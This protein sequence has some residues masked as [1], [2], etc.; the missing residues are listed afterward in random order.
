MKDEDG[1]DAL[2][3]EQGTSSA[4]MASTKF[5]D[6]IA[7]MPGNSGEDADA[8]GA[9]T[10]ILLEDS[11]KL[12]GKHVIPETWISL[13]YAQQPKWWHEMNNGAGII[14][15]VCPLIRNLYGHPLAGM[16]W[17][18]GSQKLILECGFEK[19]KGWESLYVHRKKQLFL[20]VYVDDFHMAGKA[21][22]LAPM[23][24]L[25][26]KKI[27]LDEPI[28]FNQNIYLGCTQTDVVIS[29]AAIKEKS[30]LFHS[31]DEDKTRRED[32]KLR[33][34]KE[35][36]IFAGM[37]LE[38]APV[39]APEQ[40]KA[41]AKSKWNPKDIGERKATAKQGKKDHN[42][43]PAKNETWKIPPRAW[44]YKMKG[45]AE[46]CVERYLEL[47]NAKRTSLTKVATP[48]IEDALLAPDDFISKGALSTCAS[49][50][51]LKA[52]YL[53]RLARPDLLWAVNSLAT[54][55]TKWIKACDKR[56]QRLMCYIN[57]TAQQVM[58]S[59]VGDNPED[60]QLMLFCDASFAGDL[61][62][63]KSTSGAIICLV[64]PKTFCPITWLC[65]KQGAIAHS[66]TESEVTAL[67]AGLRMEGLPA[68]DLWELVCEVFV[69]PKDGSSM[70]RE[71]M[72]AGP[73]HLPKEEAE[74]D[75]HN[76][77]AMVDY[78]PP[79]LPAINPLNPAKLMILEDNEAV[80]KMCAKMRSPTMRHVA[81]VHRVNLDSL[82]ETV[83][84][85]PNIKMR[86]ISTQQQLAD[87]F[88]K[89]SFTASTWKTLCGLLQISDSYPATKESKDL[90][91]RKVKPSPAALPGKQ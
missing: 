32:V 34:D 21:E 9:Y 68:L 65:K 38:G 29:D 72:Q 14:D 28:S 43:A 70:K 90:Q 89:G 19:I 46:G 35:L 6:I 27:T 74:K 67:D 37:P 66:S 81:R 51:V 61:K 7:H 73:H 40:S 50:I 77:L 44:E 39:R 69:T 10:Q 48:C 4:H 54:E 82:F 18:K 76:T 45:A 41:K 36:A 15:P 3:A 24:R 16:L 84:T 31:I 53:A 56:L 57:C 91:A 83:A 26:E 64:G 86:Y 71:A 58:T 25:L 20:G 8:V 85:Q 55:V 63:S 75:L 79:N 52:L 11:R 62:D 49:K 5:L 30:E 87:I 12:L 60:C 80:I 22:N 2:F 13:P 33:N 23:W 88:T 78:V 17:D 59:H 42:A 1:C 47:S